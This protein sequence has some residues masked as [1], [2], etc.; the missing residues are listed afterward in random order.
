MKAF[1]GQGLGLSHH[2]ESSSVNLEGSHDRAYDSYI[3]PGLHLSHQTEY[4]LKAGLCLPMQIVCPRAGA[5]CLCL[6][7]DIYEV[8]AVSPTRLGF[9]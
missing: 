6:D 3:R 7:R 2:P 8:E 1:P 5:V 4:S 9:P